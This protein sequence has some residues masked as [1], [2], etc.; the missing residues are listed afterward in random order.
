MKIAGL[1][2]TLHTVPTVT[3]PLDIPPY[4]TM[5]APGLHNQE[6]QAQAQGS[7]S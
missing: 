7:C 2:Q 4:V 6:R 1:C 3:G 5:T